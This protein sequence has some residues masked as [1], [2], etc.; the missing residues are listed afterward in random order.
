MH[1][2]N[3]REAKAGDFIL[4]LSSGTSGILYTVNAGATSCNGRLARVTVNDEYLN[5]NECLHVDD[6]RAANVPPPAVP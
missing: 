3:G 2:K 1:Y 4:N 6:I 5:I